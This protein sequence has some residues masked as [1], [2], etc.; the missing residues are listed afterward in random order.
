MATLY[1]DLLAGYWKKGYWDEVTSHE[2]WDRNAR[3][4]PGEEAI[5]DSRTRLTW[6]QARRWIDRI[7]LGF[8]KLGVKRGELMVIQLPN[9]VEL[10]LLVMACEKAGI[11][12]LTALRT[13]RHKEMEYIMKHVEPVGVVITPEFRGF[14]FFRMVKDINSNLPG[15]KHIFSVGDS[16]PE[17]SIS[18]NQMGHQPLEQEYPPDYL[19]TISFGPRE[20]GQIRLTT[21]TT[22]S[23]KG[24]ETPVGAIVYGGRIII[25]KYDLRPSD[26]GI[27]LSPSAGGP[28]AT[29]YFAA[30]LVAAKIV[31]LERFDAEEALKLIEREKVTYIPGVPAMLEMMIRHPNYNNY[32]LSSVRLIISAGAPLPYQLGLEVEKAM[33]CPIVQMYGIRETG[34]ISTSQPD[35]AQDERLLTVGQPFSGTVVRLVND[36]GKDMA[37]GEIGE[38]WAKGP[39]FVMGYYNDPEA[40]GQSW[41]E[42]GWVKTG[43]LGRYNDKGN[44]V[45]VGRKK[46]MIL[47]GGENIFPVEI[48]NILINH[49]KVSQ[50]AIVDM[51]DKVMGERCCAYVVLKPGQQFALDEMV[52]FLKEK[53]LAMY[54]LPERLEILDKLPMVAEG[55]KV[56][57]NAL[58]QDIVKKLRAEGKV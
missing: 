55:Q 44:I 50:I 53:N 12:S 4:Y 7:A 51:P 58:R 57:K 15:L 34:G 31:V 30:P 35:E 22:G 20:V 36:A 16:C 39:G 42:D 17:G 25:E 28:N 54:K 40:T 19:G 10:W 2:A 18:I 43:D 11:R 3:D 14:D 48:E 26:V 27:V 1:D 8:L 46:D 49:P 52:S 13:L 6:A 33:R 9:C 45:I 41:T 32:D 24:V 47:R 56:D 29:T 5:V 38:L 21:G 23:P 37:G